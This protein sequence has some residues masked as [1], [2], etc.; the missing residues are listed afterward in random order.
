MIL[1]FPVMEFITHLMKFHRV[2]YKFHHDM[3]TNQRVAMASLPPSAEEA[4][5]VSASG[6][7]AASAA[8]AAVALSPSLVEADSLELEAS[9]LLTAASAT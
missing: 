1:V 6:A 5:A 4:S 7:S 2:N 3:P 9:S 8:V